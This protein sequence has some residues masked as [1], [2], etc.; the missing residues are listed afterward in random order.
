MGYLNELLKDTGSSFNAD[1]LNGFKGDILVLFY[2]KLQTDLLNSLI[3][4]AAF[5]KSEVTLIKLWCILQNR[6]GV[7][8]RKQQPDWMSRKKLLNKTVEKSI[9]DWKQVLQTA[10]KKRA[11][12]LATN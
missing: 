8:H 12:S 11:S 9:L 6:E 5:T 2:E 3:K 7:F 10:L 4:M 1:W